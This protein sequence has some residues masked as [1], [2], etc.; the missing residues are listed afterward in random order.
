MA[1]DAAEIWGRDEY[2]FQGQRPDEHVMLVRN[3]HPIVLAPFFLWFIVTLVIPYLV[4]RFL[5]GQW[6]LWLLAVYII[7]AILW[8]CRHLYAYFNSVSVLTSQR[9][10]NIDQRGFFVRRITEAELSRIQDVSTEIKGV[11]PTIFGFGNV[12]IRTASKD[13]LIELRNISDPYEVQQA[14]VRS[15]KDGKSGE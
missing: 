10:L 13:T 5:S 6:Q 4:V 12:A 8:L 2:R 3:Q 7:S 15:L 14:I 1:N 9:I 11:F